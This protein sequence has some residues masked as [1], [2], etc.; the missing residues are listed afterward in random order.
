MTKRSD[1]REKR[2]ED[3]LRAGLR[4]FVR[5]GYSATKIIDIAREAG[6]SIGLLYRYFES[7][8]AL[9]E[10]LITIA[11]AARSGQYFPEYDSPL[12]YFENSVT[13]IFR[14]IQ[15]TPYL[16]EYFL[17]IHQAER[18]PDL[19]PAIQD[20]LQ[21]NTIIEQ[22]VHQIAEGQSQG[23]IRAGD[24]LAL[25]LIFWLS[26]Q[27]YVE[28]LVLDAKTPFPSADLFMNILKP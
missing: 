27:A 1:Q 22:S 23:T 26:I 11:L 7:A 21:K 19:P 18:N 14:E 24:P 5:K 12:A 9:Y 3:I 25:A 6:M 8:E 4:L 2:R 17:L 28:M 13:H 16:A 15:A 20:M 10:E